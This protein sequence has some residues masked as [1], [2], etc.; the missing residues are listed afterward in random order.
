MSSKGNILTAGN[1]VFGPVKKFS[2]L[3]FYQTVLLTNK[4]TEF[5]LRDEVSFRSLKLDVHF[6]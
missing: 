2:S 6:I 3:F 4:D 5:E 1:H